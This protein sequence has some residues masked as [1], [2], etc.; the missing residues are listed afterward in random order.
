LVRIS[1]KAYTKYHANTHAAVRIKVKFSLETMRRTYNMLIMSSLT[2]FLG[3][4]LILSAIFAARAFMGYKAVRRDA[5]DDFEYKKSRSMIDPRLSEDGYKRAYMRFYAPR[6]FIFTALSFAGVGILTVPMLGLIR[7]ILIKVWQASGQPDE[8]Q[9]DFLVFN[10][11]MMIGLITFWAL[12]FFI[13]ARIY[14]SKAPV[15]LRDEMLKEM[16]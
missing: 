4:V 15:S 12:I 10:L 13:N 5:H 6:K 9:P 1:F 11:M 16:D 2:L 14:Y 7:F 3:A 8:I